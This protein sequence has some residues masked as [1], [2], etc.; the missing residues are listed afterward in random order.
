MT[1]TGSTTGLL[2]KN[3]FDKSMKLSDYPMLAFNRLWRVTIQP[4]DILFMPAGTYHAVRNRNRCFSVRG[5]LFLQLFKERF[6]T[7]THNTQ[8]HRMHWTG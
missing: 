2:P 8:V 1:D 3:L 4:G 7:R 6:K 5:L